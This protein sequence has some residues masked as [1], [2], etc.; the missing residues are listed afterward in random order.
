MLKS[1]VFFNVKLKFPMNSVKFFCFVN[2]VS[3]VAARTWLI[4]GSSW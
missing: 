2:A 4:L 1:P 3:E